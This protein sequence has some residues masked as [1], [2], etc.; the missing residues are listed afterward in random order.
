MNLD[1]IASRHIFFPLSDVCGRTSSLKYLR[2]LEKTQWLK[3]SQ[4]DE[5]Q[6]K[7]LHALLIHAYENVPYYRQ[8]FKQNNLKPDDIKSVDDL[9]KLP[10]LTKGIIR[11]NSKKLLGNNV[12]R[13]SEFQ[14][15]GTTGDPLISYK[16]KNAI[17]CGLGAAYRG[18]S[19]GGYG[20]GDRYATIWRSP[21]TI[22]KYS[23]AHNH[24]QNSFRRNLLL[25]SFNIDAMTL[26]KNIIKL[27]N[28]EPKLIRAS[29][30]AAYAMAKYIE[31]EKIEYIKPTAVF[32]AAE[33]LHDFQRNKIE[34][35]FRCQ[36]F[37]SYGSNEIRSISYECEE[38]SGYHI[39]AENVIVEFIKQGE[40]ASPG[41]F[42]KIIITDLTNYAMPFIRY[43]IGDVGKC[44]DD[45]CACGRGLPLMESIDGRASGFIKTRNEKL[46]SSSFFADLLNGFS[47]IEQFQLIQTEMDC[48]N[49][50]LKYAYNPD[51]KELLKVVN[52]IEENL[53]GLH[54]YVNNVSDIPPAKSG[55]LQLVIS[56]IPLM[57]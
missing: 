10:I 48:V 35:Q 20:I 30:S 9:T 6:E 7:K 38:H 32:T 51:E 19:W 45:I 26:S 57:I 55:K 53:V 27:K 54:V 1:T 3:P 17:S 39:T 42:G 31:S 44:S 15:G 50:Y 52:N 40:K 25:P 36:V 14:S 28:Y 49:L 8:M 33:K 43:E 37:D 12:K 5:L 34:S 24:L 21:E 46:F 2:T 56:E 29:P 23:K 11:R 41:E 13:T 18:W 4:I 16:D 47:F 22:K